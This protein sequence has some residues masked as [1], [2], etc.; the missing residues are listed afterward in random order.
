[1]SNVNANPDLDFQ[2]AAR[3]F[4]ET[5]FLSEDLQDKLA[6]RLNALI[7]LPFLSEKREGQ[8]ILKIVQSLDRNTFKFIPKEI[9]AAALNRD[10]GVPGEFLD[11][12]RENLPD[13]LARL[14]PFPFLPPFIKSGLIARF[15]GILLDALKPGNSLQD[16][17]NGR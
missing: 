13:M 16:L 2:E 4:K 3:D 10:Q 9:L 6:K 14:L 1:M 8:I 15:V 12:L 5:F 11:A 7:N 17:L